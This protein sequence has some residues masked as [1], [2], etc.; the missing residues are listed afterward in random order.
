MAAID[1]GLVEM[2]F[3]AHIPREYLPDA[4]PKEEYGM[5]ESQLTYYYSKIDELRKKYRKKIIIRTGL[6]VD[7]FNWDPEPALDFINRHGSRLDYVIGSVHMMDTPGVGIWSVDDRRFDNYNEIGIN[8]V[9]EQYFDVL[10]RMVNTCKYDFV[11][12]LDLVKKFGYRYSDA[13]KYR[14]IVEKILDF[15]KRS[16]MAVEIST[17]GY[18]KYVNEIY[19]AEWIIKMI[20][21]KDI[22]VVISSD[23]HNPSEVGYKFI[24]TRDM[25]KKAG[26]GSIVRYE[27]REMIR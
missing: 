13:D 12:H 19:P 22:P 16:S 27:N 2:G 7:Y 10:G 5:K 15:V 8:T 18:R 24:E 21:E 4:V 3:S 26:V 20:G 11:G 9:Y 17:A 6:E 14:E 1:K 25:V 23:A